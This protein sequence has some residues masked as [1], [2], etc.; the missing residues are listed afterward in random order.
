MQEIPA[1][2]R[3]EIFF[4]CAEPFFFPFTNKRKVIIIIMSRIENLNQSIYE[5]LALSLEP[6]DLIELSKT[7]K[8]MSN[9]LM[10]NNVWK[11]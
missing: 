2:A 7:S 1:L 5:N 4:S 9:S 10:N 8:Q 3:S 6:R 11:R